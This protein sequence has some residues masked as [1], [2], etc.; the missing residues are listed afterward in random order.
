MGTYL[1]NPVDCSVTPN[2]I[3]AAAEAS[4][5]G[6]MIEAAAPSY[7]QDIWNLIEY[8]KTQ[9]KKYD[10]PIIMEE[11]S[12]E[13]IIDGGYDA[14]IVAIG[15]KPR[16]V[17]VPGI[18]DEIV[19]HALDVIGGKPIDGDKAVV[20]G[21]GITGAETALELA[22][23][24]KKV[25]IVEMMDQFLGVFSAVVPA[26][27]QAVHEA[28][29]KVITGMRLERVEDHMAV[30]VDRFGNHKELPADGIV[31]SAGFIP[32]TELADQLEEE[33]EK[34]HDLAYLSAATGH[35]F[36][37]FRGKKED[38]L[39]HGTIYSCDPQKKLEKEILKR[40]YEWVAHSHIDFGKLVA[41]K[42]D[43]ET[44][45]V[46]GQYK[47]IIIGPTGKEII[48]YQSEFE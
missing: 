46:L 44:L 15:G 5:G 13:T 10:I 48:F 23:A 3:K 29:I 26:Y 42:D 18:D 35:E 8:Y 20:I 16:M 9:L 40:G 19:C 45:K 12:A 33:T 30:I 41:S 36:A 22:E 2:N 14:A 17:N 37:L 28:G 31:I 6:L 47:S 34:V 32:Q 24:G 21:G 11:A 25:T 39:C 7:K 1:S 4:D 27:L 38:I 43:R